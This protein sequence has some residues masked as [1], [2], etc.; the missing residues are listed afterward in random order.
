MTS[1]EGK[2]GFRFQMSGPKSMG[3][4]VKRMGLKRGQQGDA[5]RSLDGGDE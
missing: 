2:K 4:R 3:H 5:G 1:G